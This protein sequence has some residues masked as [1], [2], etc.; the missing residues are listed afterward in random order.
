MVPSFSDEFLFNFD[1]L[2]RLRRVPNPEQIVF[3]I[4]QFL[5]II[6][7]KWPSILPIISMPV[8]AEFVKERHRLLLYGLATERILLSN[9]NEQYYNHDL[10]SVLDISRNIMQDSKSHVRFIALKA[11]PETALAKYSART[12]HLIPHLFRLHT[13]SPRPVETD[14]HRLGMHLELL[15]LF[16]LII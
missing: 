15:A 13:P 16:F 10:N 4:K 6:K 9:L 3:A 2:Q 14:L 8:S 5:V 1:L 7:D 11:H 12:Y